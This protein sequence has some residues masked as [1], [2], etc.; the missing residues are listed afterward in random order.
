MREGNL[1]KLQQEGPL[2]QTQRLPF[3]G[4]LSPASVGGRVLI[5][6]LARWVFVC[7]YRFEKTLIALPPVPF[8]KLSQA[9][10]DLFLM[11]WERLSPYGRGLWVSVP[12]DTR[13]AESFGHGHLGG[14]R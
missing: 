6:V 3:S 7:C 1:S 2:T 10:T 5:M 14:R 8:V 12:G 11:C 13:R 4:C 9:K